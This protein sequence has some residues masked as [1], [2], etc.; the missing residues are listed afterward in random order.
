MRGLLR[1]GDPPRHRA[2]CSRLRLQAERIRA[3][4]EKRVADLQ[5]S[6]ELLRLS[7]DIRS[8]VV[9]VSEA[10]AGHVDVDAATLLA[11]QRWARGEADRLDPVLSGQIFSHLRPPTQETTSD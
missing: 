11:W 3:L 5:Q 8:L 7:R 1:A 2:S 4:N 9:Q 10:M 6:G